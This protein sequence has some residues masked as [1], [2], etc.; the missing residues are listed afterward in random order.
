VTTIQQYGEWVGCYIWY[1]KEGPGWVGA[2]PNPLITVPYVTAHTSTARVPS[3]QLHI[4]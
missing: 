2:P 4:I 3:Y 1:I